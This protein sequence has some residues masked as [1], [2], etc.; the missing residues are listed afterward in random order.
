[1]A[2]SSGRS[3]ANIVCMLSFPT[4][5]GSQLLGFPAAL[6]R[7]PALL[8]HDSG[9]CTNPSRGGRRVNSTSEFSHM[10]REVR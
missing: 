1:M 7:I 8:F 2:G 4:V 10:A 6:L 9:D 5:A 3:I